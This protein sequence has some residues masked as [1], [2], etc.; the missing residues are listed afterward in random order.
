MTAA[1]KSKTDSNIIIENIRLGVWNLKIAKTSGN[2]LIQWWRD[3]NSAVP[4]IYRLFSDIFTLAPRLSTFFVF[5]KIWEGVE[6]ALLTYFSSLL[7]RRVCRF[8]L[9]EDF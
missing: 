8:T 2:M 6:D 5:C 7:L 9:L 4:I 3:I 1:E